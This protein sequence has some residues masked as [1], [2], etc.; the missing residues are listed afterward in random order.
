MASVDVTPWIDQLS[1]GRNARMNCVPTALANGAHAFGVSVTTQALLDAEYGAT[2][3]GATAPWRYADDSRDVLR[4]RGLQ[5]DTVATGDEKTLVERAHV[6]LIAGSPVLFA[7][8]SSW[9]NFDIPLDVRRTQKQRDGSWLP[10]HFVTVYSELASGPAGLAAVNPW[11]AFRHTNDD[12]HWTRL[13]VL[14]RIWILR[15]ARP[16]MWV[17]DPTDQQQPSMVDQ[18]G[19]HLHHGMAAFVKAHPTTANALPSV[20]A[21]WYA[22]DG[23]NAYTVLEDASVLHYRSSSNDTVQ[24]GGRSGA[25]LAG[26]L[27]ALAADRQNPPS[28]TPPDPRLI[29]CGQLVKQLVALAPSLP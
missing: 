11:G 21:Q 26:V 3:T 15:E 12:A 22:A 18:H 8:P 5:L 25:A 24:I 29:E 20:P 13:L 9:N 1:T 14:G 10:T 17:S 6:E 2:Y 23:S 19:T 27:R 7:I 16:V 4:G 28:S